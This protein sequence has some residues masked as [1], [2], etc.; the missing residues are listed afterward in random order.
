MDSL[1]LAW[2]YIT[3]NQ[4]R[5]VVLVACISL[6]GFLPLFLSELLDASERQLT[7][8]ADSTPLIV[9]AKGSD[10]E[11]VMNCISA[12]IDRKRHV[13]NSG[14]YG[15]LGWPMRYPCWLRGVASRL[16]L[17]VGVFSFSR[18]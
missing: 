18:T 15:I 9:G 3:G 8:R 17:P 11:L 16:S 5:S 6:I 1:Y 10:F 13:A 7:A 12:K 2:R 14:P 4:V